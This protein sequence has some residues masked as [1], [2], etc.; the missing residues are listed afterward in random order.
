MTKHKKAELEMMI[1]PAVQIPI[2]RSA[3]F[4]AIEDD[5]ITEERP[6]S[7][8]WY[9]ICLWRILEASAL[10]V[11]NQRADAL[12]D[13]KT[14]FRNLSKNESIESAWHQFFRENLLN[15]ETPDRK[16]IIKK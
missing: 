8:Y 15:M 5:I 1:L 14:L 7:E 16:V 2:S 13:V 4:I 3:V 10:Q 11:E 12:Q 6:C 9:A